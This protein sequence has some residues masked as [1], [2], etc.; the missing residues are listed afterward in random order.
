M[1]LHGI[2][3]FTL[4]A[5]GFAAIVC[6]VYTLILRIRG[7][8]LSV[9]RLL[10]VF[11]ISSLI[12][13]TVLR[14]GIAWNGL[15]DAERPMV[16]WMPFKTTLDEF[17]SGTWPFIYHVIGNL[18]WFIPLGLIMRRKSTWMALLA[19][20]LISVAIECLQWV[21]MTGMTDIDDVIINTGG[22]LTGYLLSRRIQ[23]HG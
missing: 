13:I 9:G 1:S 2:A 14:G 15:F 16:Q 11:Y 4:R 17:K 19:G 8:R 5:A 6:G 10:S 22:T 7:R 18:A 20:I 3:V 12:E 23:R 21:F